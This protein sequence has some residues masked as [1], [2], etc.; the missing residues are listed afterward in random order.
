[1]CN[2]VVRWGCESSRE[3]NQLGQLMFG[4]GNYRFIGI[5]VSDCFQ[6]S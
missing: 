4:W 3:A 1:M 6:E 5:F 2:I